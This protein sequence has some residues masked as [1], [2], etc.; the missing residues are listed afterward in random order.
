MFY[1]YVHFRK[2]DG[3]PFYVGKG[4][5]NRYLR[6][7]DRTFYWENVVSKHGLDAQIMAHWPTEAEAFEHEKFLIECFRDM[8]IQLV[9]M[10]DGG[11]GA[12]GWE[13]SLAWKQQ[14]SISQKN[15][16]ADGRNPLRTGQAIAKRAQAVKGRSLSSEHK[17]K[18][19]QSL[20]GN[21]NTLGKNLSEEH[22]A[23]IAKSLLGNKRNVGRKNSVESNQK[24]SESMKAYRAL[25]KTLKGK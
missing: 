14:K 21:K 1:T 7:N 11:E 22:K 8:G 6:K 24:R 13:P 19:A 12:S 2:D 9:N 15:K 20:I 16:F 17:T 4:K 5:G 3:K 10:T 18:I 23:K 25:Q